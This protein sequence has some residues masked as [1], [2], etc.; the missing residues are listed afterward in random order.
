MKD[1]TILAAGRISLTVWRSFSAW[2]AA[3]GQNKALAI[4]KALQ[5]TTPV[6][7]RKDRK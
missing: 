5:K 4:Q 1:E 6:A 2:V 3:T 7:Y